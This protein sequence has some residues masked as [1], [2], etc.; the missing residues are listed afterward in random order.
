M[1]LNRT[2]NLIFMVKEISYISLIHPQT[3]ILHHL[4]TSPTYMIHINSKP[5][6]FIKTTRKKKNKNP[7][8]ILNP[9][10]SIQK[11]NSISTLVDQN[12]NPAHIQPTHI[13]APTSQ[14]SSN[15]S[16]NTHQQYQILYTR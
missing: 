9:P 14:N 12:T 5:F 1:I 3:P 11:E 8:T 4:Q 16:C 2:I 7:P 13:L 10:P 6:L 15:H